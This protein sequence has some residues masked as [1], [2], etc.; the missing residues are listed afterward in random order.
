MQRGK[1]LFVIPSVSDY[2]CVHVCVRTHICVHGRVC[3]CVCV[4]T[5]F[6]FC[7]H[8]TYRLLSFI[9]GSNYE[10]TYLLLCE[11]IEESFMPSFILI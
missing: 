9:L 6:L 11:G 2:V 3:V 1:F 8:F 5:V 7:L 4:C 10:I